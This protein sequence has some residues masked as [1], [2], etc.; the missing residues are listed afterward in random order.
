MDPKDTIWEAVRRNDVPTVKALLEEEQ[1]C[2]DERTDLGET[3]LHLA[4]SC[5]ANDVICVLLRHGADLT[6]TDWESG[7]TPLHRAFYFG[8][9]TAS[10][11]LLRHARLLHGKKHWMK[12]LHELKDNDGL[13]AMVLLSTR[14]GRQMVKMDTMTRG[15]QVYTFGKVDF[16]LGF[17]L[18][19]AKVQSTPRLVDIP[20]LANV[21]AISANKYHTLALDADG[22]CYAWGFGKGGRLGMGNE[23][24]Y[25]EPVR[26]EAFASIVIRS[27]AAGENHSLALS[28]CGRVFSWGSN[29]YGQ[30]GHPIKNCTSQSRQL[31][32]QIDTFRG[33]TMR[34]IAAGSCHSAAICNNGFVYTWGCNKKGQ[35]GRKDGFGSD[36]AQPTPKRVDALVPDHALSVLYEQF[37][38]VYAAAVAVSDIHTC[39]ILNC[40]R[41]Y[42]SYGQVWQ[43]GYGFNRPSRVKFTERRR[44]GSLTMSDAWTPRWKQPF[45]DIVQ[46]SCARNHSLALAANGTVYTWGHGESLTHYASDENGDHGPL[47]L[48]QQVESLLQY[49]P[50]VS[51]WAAPNH[52][53]VVTGDGNLVTWGCGQPGVLGH[54]T[55][56]TWQPSPKRVNGAKK[57]IGVA[58]GHQHTAVLVAPGVPEFQSS[59]KGTCVPSLVDILQ[60][61]VASYIDLAN[62]PLIWQYA[63]LYS[64]KDLEHFA[65]KY[66]E[67]N[68]DAVLESM[69]RDRIDGL[70]EIFLSD[71]ETTKAMECKATPRA[72]AKR[73][74]RKGSKDLTEPAVA[75]EVTEVEVI[76]LSGGSG[77]SESKASLEPPATPRLES[78]REKKVSRRK[79][80]KAMSLNEFLAGK[81]EKQV[82]SFRVPE[83]AWTASTRPESQRHPAEE[84][85]HPS[86]LSMSY[87]ATASSRSEQQRLHSERSDELLSK[88]V[89]GVDGQERTQPSAF[90]LAAFLKP[91]KK[92]RKKSWNSNEMEEARPTWSVPSA[93]SP[94]RAKSLKEIQEEEEAKAIAEAAVKARLGNMTRPTSTINSWGLCQEPDTMT[95]VDIQKLQENKGPLDVILKIEKKKSPKAST[96]TQKKV[97]QEQR[98]KAVKAPSV[99]IPKPSSRAKAKTKTKA[100]M[101]KK[102]KH[103]SSSSTTA[104]ENDLTASNGPNGK[105]RQRRRSRKADDSSGARN[106]SETP[107]KTMPKSPVDKK[108]SRRG[109]VQHPDSR[110]GPPIIRTC[111]APDT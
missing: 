52:C 27:I 50:I 22:N 106:T 42:H 89:V 59:H 61:R 80:P 66:L 101:E 56:N 41:V 60:E 63:E 5:G 49:G 8:Q 18:P 95:L 100:K 46:I 93:A 51:I 17:H 75:T 14:S 92:M 54:G 85:G 43:F 35:L 19:H 3:S 24:D 82:V 4:A 69:P 108:K 39:V 104:K 16:Q 65:R 53:A 107:S 62:A 77:N 23:F 47:G 88:T 26:I 45:V 1:L 40:S 102:E 87:K 58:A 29:S 81:R 96:A 103:R 90:A 64:A 38:D 7:W 10:L 83:S 30:L 78:G 94:P 110:T 6:A 111:T 74:E 70:F 109:R 20:S 86:D 97:K 105:P 28:R 71:F 36:Q 25:V 76:A 84:N 48:P 31:P 2:V 34:F 98:P 57:V 55:E 79:G 9:L 13:S 12:C 73:M 44:S 15:G 37:D 32:K 33:M 68:W 72:V 91:S 21:V 11:L 99:D 67:V